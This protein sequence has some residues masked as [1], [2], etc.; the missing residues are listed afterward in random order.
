MKNSARVCRS[1]RIQM[2]TN[3][4]A[5]DDKKSVALGLNRA[6]AVLSLIQC[7]STSRARWQESVCVC[8]RPKE[9]RELAFNRFKRGRLTRR[10][11]LDSWAIH[12]IE[13]PSSFREILAIKM[14]IPLPLDHPTV[15]VDRNVPRQSRADLFDVGER[16]VVIK[17]SSSSHIHSNL[18]I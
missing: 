10:K 4:T 8:A 14:L 6:P 3:G 9:K 16:A 2:N 12:Y 7:F 11:R 5:G 17:S 1:A 18:S 13:T 15:V